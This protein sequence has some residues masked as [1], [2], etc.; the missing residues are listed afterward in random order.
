MLSWV[1]AASEH[2]RQEGGYYYCKPFHLQLK[3]FPGDLNGQC[4]FLPPFNILFTPFGS[5]IFKNYDIQSQMHIREKL[6]SDHECPGK[7]K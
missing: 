7:E 1:T 2:K 4:P 6:E 3:E 5:Q